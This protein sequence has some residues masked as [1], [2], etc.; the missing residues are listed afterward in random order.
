MGNGKVRDWVKFVGGYARKA[1]VLQFDAHRLAP[2]RPLNSEFDK[3]EGGP[4]S[5]HVLN[6]G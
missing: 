1:V 4:R 2:N 6:L 3:L 5:G